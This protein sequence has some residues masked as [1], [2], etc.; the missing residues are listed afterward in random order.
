MTGFVFAILKRDGWFRTEKAKTGP[1]VADL[2]AS[3]WEVV[4]K[5]GGLFDKF[6]DTGTLPHWTPADAGNRD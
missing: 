3:M 1:G 5:P 4:F 6:R 2:Y